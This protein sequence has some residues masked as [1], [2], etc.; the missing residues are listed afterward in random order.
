[1][2]KTKAIIFMCIITI[3]LP[4]DTLFAET[5]SKEISYPEG[6]AYLVNSD[7]MLSETYV[8]KNLVGSGK[9]QLVDTVDEA[10]TKMTSDMKS[11]IGLTLV[12]IS[13]YRSYTRQNEIYRNGVANYGEEK[14]KQYY[15][16]PGTS[17]HQ[18]G[19][20]IDMAQ[21]A[22]SPLSNAYFQNTEQY[23]WLQDNAHKY[24]FIL[25]YP[26]GSESITNINFEAWHWRYV[27]VETATFMFDNK[28][29]TLEE[30]YTFK[31]EE[32]KQKVKDDLSQKAISRIKDVLNTVPFVKE[33]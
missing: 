7:N 31:E 1:M 25:R 2:K 18:T 4:I 32:Q 29:K 21:K 11:D 28:I 6:Y 12:R 13:G 19:L 14:A 20:A 5:L 16:I 15:A 9:T 23:A 30:Y 27:G 10:L 26:E 3:V 22:V 17:E 8:P 24:G 33:V